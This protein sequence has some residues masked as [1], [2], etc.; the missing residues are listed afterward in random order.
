MRA[1][2]NAQIEKH[3]TPRKGRYVGTR[4]GGESCSGS[5]PGPESA[6]AAREAARLLGAHHVTWT[7][8]AVMT[9]A[10]DAGREPANESVR[11]NAKGRLAPRN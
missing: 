1:M 11:R 4:K 8:S 9:S 7:P 5:V 6:E 3:L 2:T 10:D